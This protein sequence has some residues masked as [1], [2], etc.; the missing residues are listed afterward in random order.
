M[1]FYKTIQVNGK[2]FCVSPLDKEE[3]HENFE[4]VTSFGFPV[5]GREN[6][7][8]LSK[9]EFDKMP[10]FCMACCLLL[11]EKEMNWHLIT[12]NHIIK[13]QERF[14]LSVWDEIEKVG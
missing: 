6:P 8:C 9:K 7:E 4:I 1:D 13:E 14:G 12:K 11:S 10:K 3:A 2:V 5:W